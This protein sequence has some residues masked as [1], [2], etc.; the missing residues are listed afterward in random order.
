M[1]RP[2]MLRSVSEKVSILFS[3]NS[4]HGESQENEITMM[5]GAVFP[6]AF[7]V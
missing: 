7:S 4:M 1:M 3:K 5:L 2:R 6:V